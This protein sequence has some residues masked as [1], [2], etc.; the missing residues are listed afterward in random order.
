MVIFYQYLYDCSSSI[1]NNLTHVFAKQIGDAVLLYIKSTSIEYILGWSR[2]SSMSIFPVVSG[3][4]GNAIAFY[5]FF[6]IFGIVHF[7]V[8]SSALS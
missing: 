1:S 6:I 7:S 2:K 8:K 5:A 4:K 3:L